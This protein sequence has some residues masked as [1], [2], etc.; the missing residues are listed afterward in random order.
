MERANEIKNDLERAEKALESAERNFKEKDFFTAAN[1]LFVACESAIYALLKVEYG[2]ISISRERIL[3]RLK[4]VD[5]HL[6]E[7]YDKSYDLRV[8]ADYEKNSKLLPLTEENILVL[9]KDVVSMVQKIKE[10]ILKKASNK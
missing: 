8:Q 7:M 3:I 6:K 1:R 5:A 4:E 2:S 9:L 10:D